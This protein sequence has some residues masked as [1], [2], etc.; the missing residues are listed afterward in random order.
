MGAGPATTMPT[1]AAATWRPRAPRNTIAIAG[2]PPSI[3]RFRA[4]SATP[5]YT[6]VKAKA[7]APSTVPELVHRHHLADRQA[8]REDAVEARGDDGVA[9]LHVLG[10]LDELETAAVVDDALDDAARARALHEGVDAA[11][12]VVD[13]EHARGVTAR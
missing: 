5:A 12:V 11:V 3:Q 2:S 8:L 13:E 4:T 9:D 6:A 10:A 1:A 7:F